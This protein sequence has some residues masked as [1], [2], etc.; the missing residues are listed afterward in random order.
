MPSNLASLGVGIAAPTFVQSGLVAYY[1]FDDSAGTVLKDYASGY[2]GTLGTGG[3]DQPDWVTAGLDF[4]P[5]NADVVTNSTMPDSVL[6]GALTVCVVANID[7]G[8]TFRHFVGKHA[9]NA[10]TAA[11]LDFRT[12]NAASPKINVGRANTANRVWQSN[13][14]V[15][16]GSWQMYSVTYSDGNVNTTPALYINTTAQTVTAV[17]GAGSGA[18]TGSSADLRIGRRA[19][20]AVQMDGKIATILIYNRALSSTEITQNYTILQSLLASR[21]ISL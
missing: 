6:L 11:P 17:G 19:D 2:D 10:A 21:G 18:A 1:R 15:T 5:G 12:D 16:L 13:G 4:V 20:G 14:A 7:T 8:S 3:S 9:G